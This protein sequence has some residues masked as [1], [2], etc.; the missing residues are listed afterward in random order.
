MSLHIKVD[1]KWAIGSD[2]EQF[3]LKRY[4]GMNK[5]VNDKME[6][7]WVAEKYFTTIGSVA[8][9]LVTQRLRDSDATTLAEALK[10]VKQACNDLD[11]VLKP[12]FKVEIRK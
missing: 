6:E 12:Y 1:D 2:T 8:I 5:K 10:V 11:N 4:R 3:T 7:L 9:Y